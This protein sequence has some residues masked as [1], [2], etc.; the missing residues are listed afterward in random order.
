MASPPPPYAD[1]T[2]ISRAAM[3]DN[4][5][6]TIVQY[7][8]NAR[9]AE[10]VVEQNALNLFAGDNNGNLVLLANANATKFYGSFYDTT[11]QPN[12]AGNVNYM[13]LNTTSSNNHVSIVN[14][15]EITVDFAGVYNIQFST[16]FLKT[17]GGTSNMEIWLEKNGNTVPYSGGGVTMSGNNTKYIAVWNY[18]EPLQAGDHV[19]LAWWS[20]D[21]GIDIVAPASE[22]PGPAV[23]SVIV[24]VTQV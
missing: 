11:N 21:A 3:K 15:D 18:V 2:G 6:V 13:A 24:T 22:G 20:S 16:Q 12:D 10:L 23:P 4:A 14:G 1:I 17:G 8:G 5:Q 7:D 19:K 9:P